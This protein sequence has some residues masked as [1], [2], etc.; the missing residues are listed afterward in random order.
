MEYLV[1]LAI[2]LAAMLYAV[3]IAGCLKETE[4]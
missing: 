3:V 4:W 2:A 1:G